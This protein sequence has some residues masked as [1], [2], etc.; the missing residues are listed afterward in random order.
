MWLGVAKLYSGRRVETAINVYTRIRSYINV[1]A[2]S[3]Q[4]M[5]NH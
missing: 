2:I 5:I 4:W 1:M 3:F